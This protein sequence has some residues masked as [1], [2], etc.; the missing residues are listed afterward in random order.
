[1]PL[2][3]PYSQEFPARFPGTCRACGDPFP[4]GAMV[5]Y[6]ADDE[7]VCCEGTDMLNGES[8]GADFD[9]F[10]RGRTPGIVVMPRGKTAKDK[11]GL[12]FMV[13]AS[14]QVECE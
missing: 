3:Q 14:G 2:D 13:H 11:C 7:L 10:N 12:C 4:L 5:R 8:N 9:S 6:N 1:M